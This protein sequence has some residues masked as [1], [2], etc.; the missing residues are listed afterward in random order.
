MEQQRFA[1]RSRAIYQRFTDSVRD[2]TLSLDWVPR[3]SWSIW[4]FGKEPIAR[5][6]QRLRDAGLQFV[7][8]AGTHHTDDSGPSAQEVR[9]LLERYALRASG[10]CG[11]YAPQVDLATDDAFRGRQALDY[12]RR[13]IEFT[14]EVGGAPAG[15]RGRWIL[16]SEHAAPSV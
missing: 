3:L 13:E 5:S 7:E 2:G 12:V 11:L 8:L 15:G 10:V 9:R 14:H 1:Q 16:K 6:F 4:M